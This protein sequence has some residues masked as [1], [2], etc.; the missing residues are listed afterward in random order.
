MNLNAASIVGYKKFRRN[1]NDHST[2]RS[3]IKSSSGNRSASQQKKRINSNTPMRTP[4]R[5]SHNK[6]EENHQTDKALEEEEAQD[7]VNNLSLGVFQGGAKGLM[8]L[9]AMKQTVS[10]I[11]DQD[12]HQPEELFDRID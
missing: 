8:K 9:A 5:D 3:K 10:V 6:Q 4:L 7:N 11:E 2:S 12:K 1:S